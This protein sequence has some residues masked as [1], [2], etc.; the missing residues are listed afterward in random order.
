M[1]SLFEND[2]F[3]QTDWNTHFNS[4]PKNVSV[5]LIPTPSIN[6][7][8]KI[9]N[10][11]FQA[12][13][14]KSASDYQSNVLVKDSILK[15]SFTGIKEKFPLKIKIFGDLDVDWQFKDKKEILFEF[16]SKTFEGHAVG[17]W[18]RRNGIISI[19]LLERK[20]LKEDWLDET[21]IPYD[22]YYEG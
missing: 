5:S 15:A 7:N 14:L 11:T 9:R 8:L 13:L 17:G 12:Y 19:D 20:D 3:F 2:P 16:K 6:P 10:Q 18:D 4:K 21:M 1:Y 22:L